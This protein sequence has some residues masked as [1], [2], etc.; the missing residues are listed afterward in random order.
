MIL[1]NRKETPL[2][3]AR[4]NNNHQIAAMISGRIAKE[5]ETSDGDF[6]SKNLSNDK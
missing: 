2:D 1:N 6:D 3:L 5:R 4:L